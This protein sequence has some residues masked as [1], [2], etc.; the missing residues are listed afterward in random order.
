MA[1]DQGKLAIRTH[2]RGHRPAQYDAIEGAGL[3]AII[4]PLVLRIAPPEITGLG[5]MS[6]VMGIASLNAILSAEV[7]LGS[8]VGART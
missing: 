4:G 1:A 6:Y 2:L 5:R 7:F 3:L 8:L